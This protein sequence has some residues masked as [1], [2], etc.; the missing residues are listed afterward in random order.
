MPG[1][2]GKIEL[3]SAPLQL[4]VWSG[5]RFVGTDPGL[6]GGPVELEF[7][8]DNVGARALHVL[9]AG[10]R[11]RLRPGSLT[12]SASLEGVALP[13]PFADIPCAGGPATVVAV[14]PSKTYRQTFLI[15]QFVRLEDSV[16]R[17]E[18]GEAG[19]L[20][21]SCRRPLPL[22]A[23]RE[24]AL[25]R[26]GAP[27]V[28]EVQLALELR[29]DDA[30]LAAL[31]DQLVD[32]VRH[33]PRDQRERPLTLLLALRAPLA[34]SRWRALLDHADPVVVARVRQA[35]QLADRLGGA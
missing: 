7:F 26:S 4:H 31:V 13:D 20:V 24:S 15:N 35:L 9:V 12:V 25:V 29:R 6:A 1:R 2:E 8:V 21:L 18:P 17:L 16:D 5:F 11:A 14:E 10:D 22:A 23:D 32:D 3:L 28:V 30:Q 27:P 19:Q 34:V 33:G